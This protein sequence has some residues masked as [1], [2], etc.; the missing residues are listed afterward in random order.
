MDPF[1]RQL[2][3]DTAIKFLENGGSTSSLKDMAKG[4]LDSAPWLNIERENVMHTEKGESEVINQKETLNDGCL[5]SGAK[6]SIEEC[7]NNK[8]I[9]DNGG[10]GISDEADRIKGILVSMRKSIVSASSRDGSDAAYSLFSLN[11]LRDFNSSLEVLLPIPPN[12]GHEGSNCLS[13]SIEHKTSAQMT[14][15]S[16]PQAPSSALCPAYHFPPPH[17]LAAQLLSHELT[18]PA[19]AVIERQGLAGSLLTAA[20]LLS[21]SEEKSIQENMTKAAVLGS[22]CIIASVLPIL[23]NL[24][25]A[26]SVI[27]QVSNYHPQSSSDI[28]LH[29]EI[30]HQIQLLSNLSGVFGATLNKL[31]N[32][33]KHADDFPHHPCLYSA[34]TGTNDILE[35]AEAA[36][37]VVGALVAIIGKMLIRLNKK[38]G[39]EGG[40]ICQDSATSQ[41]VT[42]ADISNEPMVSVIDASISWAY[43]EGKV[44]ENN[45]TQQD[46]KGKGSS[47]DLLTTFL[48]ILDANLLISEMVDD[49]KTTVDDKSNDTSECRD[50]HCDS[51]MDLNIKDENQVR[52]Y[53]IMLV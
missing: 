35:E 20:L 12:D 23:L 2:A 41:E 42:A 53:M 13:N 27:S 52:A 17:V 29:P 44:K 26:A 21:K 5:K 1:L 16:T 9:E 49:A 22:R 15:R 51:N 6:M 43:S 25:V 47:I 48:G 46:R 45:Y 34:T 32:Q 31:K 39:N 19:A 30:L 50:K 10:N 37:T 38:V 8:N 36:M 14:P 24:V 18:L 33:I 4:E 3:L 28:S 7:E 40:S 11:L